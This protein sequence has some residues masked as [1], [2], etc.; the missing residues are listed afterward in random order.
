MSVGF[1]QLDAGT[2]AP[3][4]APYEEVW[5]VTAGSMVVDSDDGRA[6]ARPGDLIVLRA[7]NCES[8]PVK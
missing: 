7:A 1:T 6:S 3:L 2:R 5:I 8:R 4:V